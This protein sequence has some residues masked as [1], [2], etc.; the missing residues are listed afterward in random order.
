MALFFSTVNGGTADACDPLDVLMVMAIISEAKG[1]LLE[2]I[3]DVLVDHEQY[4][5]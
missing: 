3:A 2:V 4:R 5:G 1:S